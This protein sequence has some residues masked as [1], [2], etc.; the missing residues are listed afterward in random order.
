MNGSAFETTI[1]DLNRSNAESEEETTLCDTDTG[2]TTFL[3]HPPLR[4]CTGSQ[5][6]QNA[7]SAY[8]SF[9]EDQSDCGNYTEINELSGDSK[10]I[11][12]DVNHVIS[13]SKP[14][15]LKQLYDIPVKIHS[16]KSKSVIPEYAVISRVAKQRNDYQ[17]VY[18]KTVFDTRHIHLVPDDEDVNISGSST[19]HLIPEHN[20]LLHNIP[21][22]PPPPAT[23]ISD[24]EKQNSRNSWSTIHAH[25]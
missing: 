8:S 1:F 21:P 5:Q 15:E 25:V 2:V 13:N 18:E 24:V 14:S 19:M 10:S 4:R 3:P 20:C 11:K 6:N 23:R 16:D 7:E 22:P 9:E 12:P 17:N